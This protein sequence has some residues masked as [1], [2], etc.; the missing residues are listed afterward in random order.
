MVISIGLLVDAAT[1]KLIC[2]SNKLLRMLASILKMGH[3]V[4]KRFHGAVKDG[5]IVN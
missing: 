3:A 4:C 2:K 1:C 5:V